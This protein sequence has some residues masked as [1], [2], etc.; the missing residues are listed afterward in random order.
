MRIIIATLL[1]VIPG[2]A[3]AEPVGERAR[4]EIG[5][6]AGAHLFSDDNEIG[7]DDFS[8]ADSPSSSIAFGIRVGYWLHPLLVTEAEVTVAPTETRDSATPVTVYG[9]RLNALINF[10]DKKIQPFAL[11]GAGFL[12]SSPRDQE[13]IR[14][15]TDFLGHL[16]LGSRLWLGDDWG[17]RADVRLLLPPSSEDD[18]AT[19][20]WQILVGLYKTFSSA[21]PR[22]AKP[23][24]PVDGDGDGITDDRDRCAGKAEDVDGFEDA[25]GCPDP[26]DDGDGFPDASDACPRQPET[27]NGVDDT[28]GCPEEDP[29]GDGIVGSADRCPDEPED[30]DGV[31]DTDG[32]ADADP[33]AD[34]DGDGVP[35]S[36]DRCPD[37]PETKNGFEDADGCPDTVPTPLQKF[38][39]TIEG[40]K[41]E[42]GSAVITADSRPT[43]DEAAAVLAK[44]ESVKLEIQG[45]TDTTGPREHNL[46]LSQQ[47]AEAVKAYLEKKGV[48]ADRLTAKGYGPDKP[49]ADNA[50]R[51]GRIANRRVEFVLVSR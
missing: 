31:D 14:T 45:H 4:F 28:D 7:V 37:G 25:D 6:F 10:T 3:A 35:D 30:V 34:R 47:R 40:I 8:D 18:F 48:A 16:G 11:V 36:G 51:E 24:A 43:L 22:S 32:C 2:V 23:A 49:K 1:L 29:D 17:V 50:T 46:R 13:D 5:G 15:D 42:L 44:F 27:K 41:F 26:D 12:T 33:G 21:P 20:D 9:W 38:T 39:G 19:V